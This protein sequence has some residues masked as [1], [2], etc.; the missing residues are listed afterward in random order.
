[1]SSRSEAEGCTVEILRPVPH[2][3]HPQAQGS[4]RTGAMPEPRRRL[5]EG[6]CAMPSPQLANCFR[7]ASS[8]MQQCANQQS[9]LSQP[10]RLHTG[11]SAVLLAHRD[12]CCAREK[13]S[14]SVRRRC[15][16]LGQLLPCCRG[17]PRPD[18]PSTP[19]HMLLLIFLQVQCGHLT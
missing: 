4:G 18:M 14:N 8:S 3:Q 15:C 12:R 9:S 19:S 7:S 1:M 11:T 10:T 2:C 16:G 5:E 13:D 17:L 6:Q